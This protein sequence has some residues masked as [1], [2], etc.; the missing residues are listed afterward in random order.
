MLPEPGHHRNRTTVGFSS[1]YFS[2]ACSEHV[3]VAQ[4]DV[5]LNLTGSRPSAGWPGGA[6]D[7]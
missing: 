6:L 7:P 2:S 1:V 5:A 4:G 3:L